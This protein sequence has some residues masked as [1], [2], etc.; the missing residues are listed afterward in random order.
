MY[1]Y[2]YN[3]KSLKQRR[4]ELRANQ[5]AAEAKMWECLKSRKLG[6]FKFIRQYSIG[7]YVIDF[8]CAQERLGIEIDGG[9]HNTWE[10]KNYDKD[11]ENGLKVFNIKLLRFNNEEVIEN[12]EKVTEK[13]LLQINIG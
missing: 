2:P 5:T 4:R 1:K 8:Y 9:I 10:N 12:I 6:G 7:P 13:I 11:R 3:N